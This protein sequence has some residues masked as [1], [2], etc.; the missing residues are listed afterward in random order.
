MYAVRKGKGD[1]DNIMNEPYTNNTAGCG[2]LG[3]ACGERA[4][5]EFE[6]LLIE[7]LEEYSGMP[8]DVIDDLKTAMRMVRWSREASQTRDRE[9]NEATNL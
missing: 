1:D 8:T 2:F 6:R 5:I 7:E 9:C 3:C 4:V